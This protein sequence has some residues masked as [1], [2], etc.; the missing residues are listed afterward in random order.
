MNHSSRSAHVQGRLELLLFKLK[1]GQLF[2]ISVLKVREVVLCPPLTQI[3]QSHP[4]VLG[5]ASLRNHQVSVVDL[6]RTLGRIQDIIAPAD[7]G[8]N[9]LIITEFNRT[10]QGF[11]VAGMQRIVICDWAD[12]KLPPH[13][14]GHSSFITG[15]IRIDNQLVEILDVERILGEIVGS[16]AGLEISDET[17]EM[18]TFAE[19]Q[20]CL[21]LVVDDSMMA[22][23]QTARVLDKV[24]LP[25]EIARDGREALH[26]LESITA[27]RPLCLIISDIEMP[28][29]DGYTL[30]RKIRADNRFSDIYI[31]LHT[32][33]NG[34]INTTI[35]KEVG[36]NDFLT[37]F[38]G[39][40]LLAAIHRGLIEVKNR[41]L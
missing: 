25:Y 12:V 11:L 3:P 1:D 4:N 31:L 21:I 17:L 2:G 6:A 39:D 35:A 38:H 37:K 7:V 28:E 10:T 18:D 14:L 40:D 22:R 41:T 24:Q 34:S 23:K 15:V 36:A 27:R 29:M 8:K 26:K 30:T 13:G 32:S 19:F 5:I 20:D 33:L 16:D 9:F